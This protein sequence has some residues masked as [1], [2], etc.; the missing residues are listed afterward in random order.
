MAAPLRTLPN[1]VSV[2]FYE[3]TS[4][5]TAHTFAPNSSEM[6]N[7][8]A[9]PLGSTN[10]DFIGAPNEF[11]DVF[12]SDSDGT[13]NLDGGYITIDGIYTGSSSGLNIAEVEL[14]FST[15]LLYDN[16][17]PSN[18]T[19]RAT[20]VTAFTGGSSNF[21]PASVNNAVDNNLGTS[22]S[23]GVSSGN[24]R[25]SI[26]VGFAANEASAVPEPSS[27]VLLAS[28]ALGLVWMQRSRARCR[29]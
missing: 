1:L 17:F 12:Y 26:T 18:G 27:W 14:L 15:V 2:T 22:T 9:N 3:A 16:G 20:A 5:N 28:G 19:Y 13:F 6:T 8:L 11:Y 21:N 7:R 29:P 25:M 10:N 24:N 23:M 4:G